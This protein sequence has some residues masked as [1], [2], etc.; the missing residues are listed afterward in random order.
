[1]IMPTITEL[2]A[3]K[4]IN[5][6]VKFGR[7]TENVKVAFFA[8]NK[9]ELETL[10]RT[11]DSAS[12]NR[13]YGG[14][15]FHLAKQSN[16]Y[17]ANDF[18]LVATGVKVNSIGQYEDDFSNSIASIRS[19][20]DANYDKQAAVGELPIIAAQ[21]WTQRHARLLYLN[22]NKYLARDENQQYCKLW[23]VVF[24]NNGDIL[25]NYISQ[26]ATSPTDP[27]TN[28]V[29]I[30]FATKDNSGYGSINIPPAEK[31]LTTFILSLSESA[32][33]DSNVIAVRNTNNV[34]EWGGACP[35]NCGQCC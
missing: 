14:I 18:L 15:R 30:H 25:L 26:T 6:W 7:F 10:L 33:D 35:P 1:M 32:T 27:Q 22:N 24:D 23:S 2:D 8:F 20:P 4:Y 11:T 34:L 16:V 21:E 29:L 17:D 13:L 12:G 5:N 9:N 28:F 19:N 31:G 3:L